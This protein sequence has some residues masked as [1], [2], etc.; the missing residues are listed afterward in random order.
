M[1]AFDFAGEPISLQK[2]FLPFKTIC[3]MKI[4]VLLFASCLAS[5][6][7]AATS[8]ADGE[9]DFSYTF[10]NGFNVS[11][12]VMGATDLQNADV[13]DVSSIL[14]LWFDGTPVNAPIMAAAAGSPSPQISVDVNL[15][16]FHFYNTSLPTGDFYCQQVFNDLTGAFEYEESS[17]VSDDGSTVAY[18][19]N[20]LGMS[21]ANWS[22]AAVPEPSYSGLL[23]CL[24]CAAAAFKMLRRKS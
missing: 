5:F 16:S 11:G 15:N 9:Y 12:V 10:A 2:W 22:F 3:E 7:V 17:A 19:G 21:Q 4:E 18:L 23:A 24:G 20:E 1:L 8:K 13:V 6:A 14:D